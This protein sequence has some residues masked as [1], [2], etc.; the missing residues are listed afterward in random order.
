MLDPILIDAIDAI[1]GEPY[2]G[3]A[4]RVTWKGRDPLA[5]NL[6]GGRW[7]PDGKFEALY[8]N[9]ERSGAIAEVYYHL[10]Q[11]PV[12]SSSD[13]LLNEVSVSVSNILSLD[14]AQ[15]KLLGIE[16]PLA[17][18]ISYERS[19]SIGAAAYMLDFQ[20]M[21]IP[22][23]RWDSMNLVLFLDRVDLNTQLALV[24]SEDVN[25]PAWIEQLNAK[26]SKSSK[27]RPRS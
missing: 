18:R 11:A 20:G 16:D 26:R 10:S 13:V 27:R 12:F 2:E 14:T 17:K 15:L 19:Q 22:S 25:W 5:G 4:Y 3:S 8:L 24:T 9:L 6:G 21:I 23:A 1:P 7:S